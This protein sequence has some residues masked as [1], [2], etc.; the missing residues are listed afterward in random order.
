MH[1]SVRARLGA[2]ALLVSA[3][4]L[5]A[6]SAAPSHATVAHHSTARAAA[7]TPKLHFTISKSGKVSLAKSSSTFRPGRVA[8]T[9]TTKNH[10]AT[11]GFVRFADG[12][13]FKKFQKDLAATNKGDMTALTRA[14]KHT[15]FYGGAGDLGA[16][17]VSGTVV[18]PK[19]GSYM[20]YN[21]G[22]NLP[23]AGPVLH[24][25]GRPQHRP[26]P[27]TTA[28]LTAINGLRFGGASTI[29]SHGTL[30][31]KNN[32][33]DSPHFFEVDQVTPGTTTQQILDYFQ[34]GSQ[35]P[36]AFFAGPGFGTEVI[37]PHQSMTLKYHLAPGTYAEMCF[38]PDPKM[39]GMPHAAMGMIRIITV[40]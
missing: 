39:H 32:A 4:G 7:H 27:Q 9:V 22:G 21:F 30:L 29:P 6:P 23:K 31:L 28:T 20:A 36:P 37:G 15:T 16:G 26:A 1:H 5:I 2:A 12:Y 38:F 14:I 13:S 25:T 24:A 33:V 18:L 8:F 35:A 34:S 10:N 3:V 11:L 17:S 19:A 40:Q